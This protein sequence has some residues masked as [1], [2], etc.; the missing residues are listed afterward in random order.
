MFP[1]NHPMFGMFPFAQ[2]I[3]GPNNQQQEVKVPARIRF[4]LELLHHLTSKTAVR[5]AISEHQIQEV[6]G[7]ALS[8]GEINA[9]ATACHVIN[10]YLLGKLTP[11]KWEVAE[12]VKDQPREG[13]LLTCMGC[14][15]Q[16]RNDCRICHGTGRV[17]VLPINAGTLSV[18][19]NDDDQDSDAVIDGDD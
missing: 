19:E 16:V 11:D 10:D 18:R 17:V 13:T 6:D 2:M 12:F 15:P 3:S 4:A 14:Y 8:K 1:P 5:V 7:Q 9:Q